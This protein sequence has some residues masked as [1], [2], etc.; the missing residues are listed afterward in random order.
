MS[1]FKQKALQTIA[2]SALLGSIL[3]PV[4]ANAAMTASQGRNVIYKTTFNDLDGAKSTVLDWKNQS[5]EFSFDMTDADWTDGLELLLSAD[6]LGRVSSRTPIMVQFNNGKPRPIVTRGQGFDTRI[7]LDKA[8]IRPRRNKVKFTYK[9]PSGAECLLPQHG[10]WRLNF[11]ESFVVVKARAKS[12]TFQLREIEA[13]L[14]NA[15]TAPK[16][17]SILARGQNT[18]KLQALAAQG[19]GMRVKNLPDFKTT[20]SSSEFEIVLG[21]RDELYGWVNDKDILNG[22]GPRIA[23]HDGRPM[24]LVIT[25]DTDEEVISTASAFATHSLPKSHRSKT[26]LGE[27]HLQPSFQDNYPTLEGKIKISDLGG[28]YFEEGWGPTANRVKFN[29]ADP[30]ASKGEILLRLASNKNV[31]KESRVSV[32]LNGKS[33]GYTQLDKARKTVAFDIPEGSLLGSEN[34]LT[35]TPD[36]SLAPDGLAK[37]SGCN[38]IQK[39]P[40]FYLGDGSKLKIETAEPSP[41]AE[42]SKMTATGA[43][44]SLENGKDTLVILPAGSSRDYAASLKVLAKL[45]K[46][47]GGGW[48]DADFIR[49]TNYAAMSP[50]KNILFV[51]PSSALRGSLRSSA[52][53]GL[54]SA[55]RGKTL[56]GTGRFIA[57]NDRFASNDTLATM[58]LYAARQA[59]AGRIGQGGVA[60]LYP[61]P[62]GT[63][64]VLGVITNVPGR[65]F[66]YVANDLVKPKHWNALEGSVARW[67]KSNV[68]MA[69]TAIDIPGYVAPKPK[70]G[71]LSDITSG[72]SFPSFEMP[73]F[74]WDGFSLDEFDAELAK[75]RIANFKTRLHTL[76]TETF[77]TDVSGQETKKTAEAKAATVK[78]VPPQ[79]ATVKIAVP[80]VPKGTSAEAPKL[81]LRGLSEV[82]SHSQGALTFVSNAKTN[83]QNWWQGHNFDAKINGLKSKIS[84]LG[85]IQKISKSDHVNPNANAMD[86]ED[87]SMSTLLLFLIIG[88]IFALMGLVTPNEQSRK[89]P[90]S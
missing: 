79:K 18:A 77:K 71:N 1:Q 28:T 13:R 68:L 85:T 44:F 31:N 33:L 41:V 75:A 24:R 49:S 47:S 56:N 87:M 65:G 21:R 50:E 60:A 5:A 80:E 2:L 25:G 26:S 35:I 52:P 29:V 81:E 70:L 86:W 10:G 42:L 39:M 83:I 63:G 61:S 30:I 19:V 59:K 32:M 23:V 54:S 53:K 40:G 3:A 38:F 37:E 34:L 48:T 82:R 57:E 88:S 67:N 45:A 64:K 16:S 8:K 51:G 74:E 22:S 11:D 17:I 15:T 66:S 4:T 84:A 78:F 89:R 55:L 20:K 9:T 14:A 76:V 72:F 6:P 62:L 43:P 58:R 46:S 36:L 7:K 73:S 69:Q 27:M 90:R 12:R